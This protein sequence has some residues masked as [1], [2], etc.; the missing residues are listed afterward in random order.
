MPEITILSTCNH[1]TNPS[2]S[3]QQ[4]HHNN[5][6]NN[7]LNN[8]VLFL[9]FLPYHVLHKRL[10]LGESQLPLSVRVDLISVKISFFSSHFNSLLTVLFPHNNFLWQGMF[11]STL[12]VPGDIL[13]PC[14][15]ERPSGGGRPQEGG[16][17][18]GLQYSGLPGNVRSSRQST[19]TGFFTYYFRNQRNIWRM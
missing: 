7:H 11:C 2:L 19:S 16:E 14:H 18:A 10:S 6:H 17:G 5:H 4:P 8:I 13:Q 9:L 12:Q 15:L 3:K 1:F